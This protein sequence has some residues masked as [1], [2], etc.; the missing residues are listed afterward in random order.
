MVPGRRP[1]LKAA[2]SRAH[3]GRFI[4]RFPAFLAVGTVA[5]T[6]HWLLMALLIMQGFSPVAATAVGACTGLLLSYIGHCYVT[7][8][9]T[10]S[11][12][13]LNGQMVGP[14]HGR[15]FPGFCVTASVGWLINLLVFMLLSA[16]VLSVPLSQMIATG[17]ATVCNYVLNRQF[18]FAGTPVATLIIS[19]DRQS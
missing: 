14:S 1:E 12:T 2:S 5:T 6:V 18:V 3:S 19:R 10:T 16:L 17:C 4:E 15:L 7:F 13:D 11:H 9:T 8:R